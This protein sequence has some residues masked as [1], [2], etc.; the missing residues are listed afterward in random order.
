MP[1]RGQIL[2]SSLVCSAECF[3]SFL[4]E[5]KTSE[6]LGQAKS[7]CS[8][9]TILWETR[10][11]GWAKQRPHI[12]QR[13]GLGLPCF[14]ECVS[15][16]FL[17]AKRMPHTS[18]CG[19]VVECVFMWAARPLLHTKASLHTEHTCLY[20]FECTCMWCLSRLWKWY[21]LGQCGHGNRCEL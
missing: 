21:D 6:H 2:G 18:H 16:R 15:R 8:S 12:S 19:L 10:R 17:E 11:Y 3:R 14:R 9:C 4:A 7:L 5:G 13:C 1:E 20:S